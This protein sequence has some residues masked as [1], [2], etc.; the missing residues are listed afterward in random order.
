MVF[1][2]LTLLYL[3]CRGLCPLLPLSSAPAPARLSLQRPCS[4]VAKHAA[5][6]PTP[7]SEVQYDPR[8]QE[9][10]KQP[11]RV[12]HRRHQWCAGHSR[13][14]A[15]PH[16]HEREEPSEHVGP[17]RHH[18]ERDGYCQ[19]H[20][21]RHV[22]PQQRRPEYQ[23]PQE[24]SHDKPRQHLLPKHVHQVRGPNVPEGQGPDHRRHGL[25]AR[26]AAM[27]DEQRDEVRDLHV[28]PQQLLVA[29][30]HHGSDHQAREEHDEPAAA[31]ADHIEHAL[32][33][34]VHRGGAV[35]PRRG[36]SLLCAS[37][38]GGASRREAD[39]GRR[40]QG[41]RATGTGHRCVSMPS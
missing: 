33:A 3:L 24:R 10:Y 21:G 4:S 9:V 17:Q 13:V 23:Q 31:V 8:Y 16:R 14:E 30:Y 18:W 35:A 27:A 29:L 12:H 39:T 5:P 19:A 34:V 7:P 37:H 22:L 36:A 6:L 11:A 2:L 1:W 41:E 15:Q 40:V 32:F 38:S 26:V 20:R 25:R 28:L